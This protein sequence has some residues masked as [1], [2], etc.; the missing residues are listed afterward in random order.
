MIKS[1]TFLLL[2][3]SSLTYG[4]EKPFPLSRFPGELVTDKKV[5]HLEELYLQE[6]VVQN[7]LPFF[8]TN[9][10]KDTIWG[11]YVVNLPLQIQ[12]RN[13]RIIVNEKG[14]VIKSKF[15]PDEIEDFVFYMQHDTVQ[16]KSLKLKKKTWR[17]IS[18]DKT[19]NLTTKSLS[20]KTRDKSYSNKLAHLILSDRISLYTIYW[21]KKLTESTDFI[22]Y[23]NELF[24]FSY[25]YFIHKGFI[26]SKITKNE[27]YAHKPLEW[28]KAF[29]SI[30]AKHYQ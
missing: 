13:F 2:T 29:N 9:Y 20:D 15:K 28:I 24:L 5:N 1:L 30:L 18:R 26:S 7:T 17:E 3:I 12:N 6:R 11:Y 27:F 21:D 14:N 4:Q 22:I 16:F 25:E 8:M 23:R 19:E 10:A